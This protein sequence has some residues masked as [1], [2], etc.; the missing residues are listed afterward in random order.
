MFKKSIIT[1][2]IVCASLMAHAEVFT[3]WPGG[4]SGGQE[5]DN[6]LKSTS[7]MD[8][9]VFINGVKADLKLGL[10]RG[11]LTEILTLLKKQFPDAKFAAAG[12]SLLVKQ[13]LTDGWHKRLLLVYFGDFFPLLQISITL[14]PKPAKPS[15]W[16]DALIKT[17][18]G[19]PLRYIYFPKRETWYGMFKTTMEPSQALAEV[20]N[21]LKAQ[22][23]TPLTGEASPNYQG[24]G[25][26]FMKK[27]SSSIILISFSDDGVA[28]VISRKLK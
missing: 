13:K 15:R 27:N 2:T 19:I 4:K 6:F 17:S 26:M 1:L 7:L 16:P 20:S 24:H 28:N 22:G 8:E 10:V 3:L 25:E 21:S 5:L 14:P 12:D 11:S 9:P 18:D 23:W